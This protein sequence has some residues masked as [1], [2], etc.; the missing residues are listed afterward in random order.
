M[1]NKK[2]QTTIE[3]NLKKRIYRKKLRKSY[4]FCID[5][6]MAS[7]ISVSLKGSKAG[8]HWEDLVGYTLRDLTTHLESLFDENMSWNNYGSYWH[9]DH[10]KPKSLFEYKIPE[11][12]E[13]K[14]CWGLKNLQPL[15][16]HKNLVKNNN[17]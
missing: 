11:S 5:N 13:F 12:E 7:S 14:L 15:E 1:Y 2:R 17:Y 16:A 10:I 4:R 8:R 9:I 3:Y 6:N